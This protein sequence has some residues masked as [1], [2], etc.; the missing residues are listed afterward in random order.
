MLENGLEK[1]GE[2]SEKSAGPPLAGRVWARDERGYIVG[3]GKERFGITP[4]AMTEE[5]CNDLG[6]K[7]SNRLAYLEGVRGLLGVQTLLWIFF[8]LF[9]PAIVTDTDLDGTQPAMFVERSP[10]WMSV[11]RKVL[12]PLLFDG[13]LQMAGFIILMGRVA[14]QTFVERRS[15]TSLAG[16]CARRP[17]RLVIPVALALALTSIV[18]VAHGYKHVD[19]L[20]QRLD[21]DQ[22]LSAP[23]VWESTI[24]YFN[25]MVAFFMAPQTLKDSRAVLSLP[26]YGVFWF[27]QV[28]FQ[29]T[30]VLA[31]VAWTL[32]YLIL[33]YKIVASL[34]VVAL[35]A[36]VARWSWYTLTGFVICEFSVVH[37]QA[38]P[39]DKAFHLHLPG[40]K[41]EVRL[42]YTAIPLALILLGTILKYLW[43]AALPSKINNE[44]VFHASINTA[45][46]L[47]NIDPSKQAYPRYDNWIL[48]TGFLILLELSPRLQAIFSVRPLVLLGRLSFSIVLISGTVM[49][50]LGSL[51]YQYLVEQAG[52]A[53]ASTLT[54]VMFLIFVPLCLLFALIWSTLIDQ[55]SLWLSRK[56]FQFLI[57][58]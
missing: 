53:N 19:W 36:W 24:L 16:H 22:I 7:T 12:S 35:S 49:M 37:R 58:K 21:N 8:R 47:R 43:I 10:E 32:P 48:F 18:S 5:D 52:I 25:S 41:D 50:S 44:L 42:P 31:V 29:Q 45:K 2:K 27:I 1:K 20:A 34:L 26:P 30:Y 55:T 9:A 46:L 33:K 38:L 57:V 23:K 39:Q 14:F 15:E 4:I 40:V 28:V 56:F 3:E 11:I 6:R 17:I 51:V 13:S 54:G